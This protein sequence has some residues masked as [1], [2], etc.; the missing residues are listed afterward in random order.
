MSHYWT[1]G[2][3]CGAVRFTITDEPMFQNHCQCVDC[4]KRSGTGHGS[5]LTF[6]SRGHVKLEGQA[7]EWQLAGD[8]GN[9]KSH[10][11]CPKCGT[12][13][14]LTFAANPDIFTVHATAL[15]HPERFAPDALTYAI[16]GFAWDAIAPDVPR[17]DR[18]L[19]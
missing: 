8:S 15:D 18:M 1:G 12:P 4:Q 10:W 19:S 14:Y 3:A 11:F 16:R 2:C 7:R 13:V 5:Y 17:F 9:A 6:P